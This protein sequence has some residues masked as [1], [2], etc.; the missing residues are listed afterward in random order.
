MCVAQNIINKELTIMNFELKKKLISLELSDLVL[1]IENNENNINLIDKSF[2][3]RLELLINNLIEIIY[4]N[5]V[6]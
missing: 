2:D 3:E 5:L 4:N 1:A 6:K